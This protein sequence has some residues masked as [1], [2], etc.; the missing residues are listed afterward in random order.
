VVIPKK[1]LEKRQSRQSIAFFIMSDNEAVAKPIHGAKPKKD[2]YGEGITA[3]QGRDESN[4]CIS[5]FL[6]LADS[7]AVCRRLRKH[8]LTTPLPHPPDFIEK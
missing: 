6:P 5:I 4:L 2:K 3:Y 7:K 1:E 8:F